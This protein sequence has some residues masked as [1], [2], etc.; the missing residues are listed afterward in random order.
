MK[1]VKDLGEKEVIL[2][3]TPEECEAIAELLD[4]EGLK[5]GTGHTYLEK[6]YWEK[7]RIGHFCFYP[8]EG[9]FDSLSYFSEFNFIVHNAKDFFEESI[10]K[11]SE[12]IK[13]E[14]QSIISEWHKSNMQKSLIEIIRERL[15]EVK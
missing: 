8:K 4:K 10:N 3:T 9:T 6:K 2:C 11:L 5:W 13:Q 7:L 1:Q 15:N 12:E 14:L